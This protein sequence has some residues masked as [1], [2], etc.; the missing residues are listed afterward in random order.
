MHSEVNKEFNSRR[1]SSLS[2]LKFLACISVV[3][4]HV[5]FPGGLG[6]II[7]NCSS[8]A[9]PVFLMISG[10]FSYQCNTQKIKGRVLKMLRILIFGMIVYFIYKSAEAYLT[11]SFVEWIKESFTWKSPLYMV[12]FCTLPWAVLLWYLIAMIEIYLCWICVVKAGKEEFFDN[13]ILVVFVITMLFNVVMENLSVDWMYKTNFFC[14]AFPW[15][16]FGHYVRGK[17]INKKVSLNVS[18]GFLAFLMIVGFAIDIFLVV[19]K[20]PISFV[21]IGALF[22]APSIFLIGINNS[23]ICISKTIEYLGD[24]VSLY[25]YLFHVPCSG[26]MTFLLSKLGI[27]KGSMYFFIHPLIVVVITILG[28]VCFERILNRA[29]MSVRKKVY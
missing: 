4:I 2:F 26:A 27:E 28:S 9:V 17:E 12:V 25:V 10:Y 24:K 7:K 18:N 3:F 8:W 21:N 6:E 1:N 14:S 29:R 15:F 19:F 5:V 22:V 11:G 16:L 13:H 20:S 23:Q